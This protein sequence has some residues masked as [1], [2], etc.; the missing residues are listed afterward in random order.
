LALTKAHRSVEGNHRQAAWRIVLDHVPET[1]RARVVD[2]MARV[3]PAWLAYRD[4]VARAVG[5]ERPPT[6][7]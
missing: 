2:A 4:D 1:A 7:G 5:L 3:L 6:D